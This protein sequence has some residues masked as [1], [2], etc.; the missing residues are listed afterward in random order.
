[1]KPAHPL[2]KYRIAQG[3]TLSEMAVKLDNIDKSTVLRWEKRKTPVPPKRFDLI[4][5]VT[6]IPRHK[7]R[8]DI[9]KG[10]A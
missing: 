1:M 5:R 3:L 6:G 9:F 8:P 4:E 7:L 10:A 2:E